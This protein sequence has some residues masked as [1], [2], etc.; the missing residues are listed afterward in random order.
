MELTKEEKKE[1][2]KNQVAQGDKIWYYIS[3]GLSILFAFSMLV[4]GIMGNLLFLIPCA[5]MIV[6]IILTIVKKSVP[7][8]IMIIVFYFIG[9]CISYVL[10]SINT[11]GGELNIAGCFLIMGV[12]RATV[13]YNK[14]LKESDE[15]V[16][17][18]DNQ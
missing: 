8:S 16:E 12:I 9:Q 17:K 4:A 15:Q 3:I 10:L 13:A 1:I 5:G 18:P 11:G 14:V 2:W 7:A 6:S